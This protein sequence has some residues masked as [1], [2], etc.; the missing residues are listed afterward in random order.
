MFRFLHTIGEKR[1]KNLVKSFK[2]NGLAPCVHGNTKRLPHNTLPLSSVEYVVRFLL[3]FADQN[4]LLLPGRI[5]GYSRSDIKLLP[6][7][8]SK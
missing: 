6:S 7:S 8:L 4:C 5:P 2:A 3:N 1:L